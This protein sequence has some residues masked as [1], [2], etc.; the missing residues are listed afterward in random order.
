MANAE[1]DGVTELQ[2]YVMAVRAKPGLTRAR[3]LE[4]LREKHAPL[5][6]GSHTMRQRLKRYVQN[7]ALDE[8]AV[9]DA[10]KDRDWVIE[11]WIDPRVELPEPPVAPDAVLVR[12]DEARFPDRDT[13]V[14][15]LVKPLPLLDRDSGSAN[16]KVFHFYRYAAGDQERVGRLDNGA[17]G[18]NGEV[19]ERLAQYARRFERDLVV[20]SIFSALPEYHCVDISWFDSTDAVSAYFA[21]AALQRL[22]SQIPGSAIDAVSQI[23]LVTRENPVFSDI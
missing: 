17:N 3:A 4:H 11:G 5:V 2:K 6:R 13:L 18:L 12:E 7:H 14:R 1:A 21:D 9:P 16:I 23:R 10:T 22:L 15:L 8:P 20:K 19:A